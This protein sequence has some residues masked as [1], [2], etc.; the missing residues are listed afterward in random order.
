M[1]RRGWWQSCEEL[2]L[3]GYESSTAGSESTVLYDADLENF[4]PFHSAMAKQTLVKISKLEGG[5]E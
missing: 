3:P 5:D 2:E 1:T 4:D